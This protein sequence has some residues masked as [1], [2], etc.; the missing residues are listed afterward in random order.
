[1][2]AW[3]DHGGGPGGSY[4]GGGYGGGGGWAAGAPDMGELAPP[5]FGSPLSSAASTMMS[6]A[7]TASWGS[8]PSGSGS[9]WGSYGSPPSRGREF[10]AV[11]GVEQGGRGSVLGE[12]AVAPTQASHS[13]C[14]S[15]FTATPPP[16]RRRAQ[17]P[18]RLT[19]WVDLV[20][21]GWRIT[22]VAAVWHRPQHPCEWAARA[23]ARSPADERLAPRSMPCPAPT[24]S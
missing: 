11:V 24:R 7:P 12:R 5:P 20:W 6:S 18:A 16:L 22:A 2:A 17:P 1:M 19:A 13:L 23:A 15:N 14:V 21:L 4:G 8:G 9:G 3:T 10:F